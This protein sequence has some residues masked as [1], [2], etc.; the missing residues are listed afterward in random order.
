MKEL[1][2]DW[3]MYNILSLG[4][5]YLCEICTRLW[6][7]YCNIINHRLSY[8]PSITTHQ[9]LELCIFLCRKQ[10][11]NALFGI[12]SQEYCTYARNS[13]H[14][15]RTTAKILEINL[16]CRLRGSL[17]WS[18]MTL[19]FIGF[20]STFCIAVI[21]VPFLCYLVIRRPFSQRSNRSISQSEQLWTGPGEMGWGS[22]PK[23]TSWNRSAVDQMVTNSNRGQTEWQAD[24]TENI[25][26][27]Q[28]RWRVGKIL[29]SGQKGNKNGRWTK[30]TLRRLDQIRR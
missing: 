28:L 9:H 13:T 30:C 17:T 11:C 19:E 5:I 2:S 26:F 23:W 29:C 14:V 25:T 18:T 22:F 15:S 27:L 24:T 16:F 3:E 20:S 10:Y 1:E 12:S 21:P 8:V 4:S 6:K 7:L